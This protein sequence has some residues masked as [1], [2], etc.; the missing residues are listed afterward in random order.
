MRV[1]PE[2]FLDTFSKNQTPVPRVA[3]ALKGLPEEEYTSREGDQEKDASDDIGEGEWI[4][5][6]ERAV[7]EEAGPI[8][9]WFGKQATKCWSKYR[10]YT[11]N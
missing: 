1:F 4:L 8:I 6:E 11:P 9:C 7:A 10:S 2:C 3:F 5:L